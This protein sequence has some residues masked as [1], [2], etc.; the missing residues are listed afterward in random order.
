MGRTSDAFGVNSVAIGNTSDAIGA[1]AVAIGINSD[2]TADN[3]VALGVLSDALATDAV[4]IGNTGAD[5]LVVINLIR[6]ESADYDPY[7]YLT[8]PDNEIIAQNDDFYNLNSRIIAQLPE[9]SGTVVGERG[10]KLSGGEKQR[11]AIAR[12]I[13]KRPPILVFDEATSS[14]DSQSERSILSALKEISQGHTSMVIAHRL[15]TVIDADRII[16]MDQ[17]AMVEQGSHRKLLAQ[18][19]LYFDLWNAQLREHN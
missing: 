2:A 3:T 18:R 16:V 14:L 17:G 15:S 11:V 1:N 13:L 7:L 12:T 5:D 19:G 10:L 4:A 6:H 8:T 9:G